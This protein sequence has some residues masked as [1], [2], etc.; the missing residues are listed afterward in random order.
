M[1]RN[2]IN[3]HFEIFPSAIIVILILMRVIKEAIKLICIFI[4]R[5][6]RHC[7]FVNYITFHLFLN[8]CNDLILRVLLSMLF[9]ITGPW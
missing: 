1:M 8:K 3:V 7:C 9:H 2:R 6:T 4:S 5:I